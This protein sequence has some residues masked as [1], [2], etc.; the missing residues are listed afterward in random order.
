M[1]L[2]DLTDIAVHLQVKDTLLNTMNHLSTT[3]FHIFQKHLTWLP[4]PIPPGSLDGA[5]RIT[6]VDKIIQKFLQSGAK[7]ITIDI[8]RR[9]NLNNL[10][11]GLES[12]ASG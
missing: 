11:V 7:M 1:A 10:A 4:D 2:P 8:L 6:T 3:E 5:D 12:G 9:M